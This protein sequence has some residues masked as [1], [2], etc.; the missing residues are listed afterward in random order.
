MF[1]K[2]KQ[3]KKHFKHIPPATASSYCWGG[4]QWPRK[5]FWPTS[6]QRQSDS[7]C[8]I[9][10]GSGITL[11]SEVLCSLHEHK[12]GFSA[13][14]PLTSALDG[15]LS[16]GC[17]G[18]HEKFSSIPSTAA[19]H[20]AKPNHQNHNHT[21]SQGQIPFDRPAEKRWCRIEEPIKW[22]QIHFAL[23]SVW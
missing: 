22:A 8:P 1:V 9:P 18:R 7:R 19:L 16:G 15:S 4:G 3:T 12:A 21:L 6:S 11:V 17:P 20:P 13:S 5:T 2:W 23:S 10:R 14:A